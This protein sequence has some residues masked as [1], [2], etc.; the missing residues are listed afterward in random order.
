MNDDGFAESEALDLVGVLSTVDECAYVWDL[1]TD[2][3]K[4]ESN[5]ASV[6]GLEDIDNIVS[7]SDFEQR[8]VCEHRARRT[9]AIAASKACPYD[10]GVP[11]RVQYRFKPGAL[12]GTASIWIED[13]GRWWPGDDGK[14]ALARGTIRVVNESFVAEQA[15]LHGPERDEL[16]NHLNRTRLPHAVAAAIGRAE[17]RRA[18]SAFLMIAVNNL[19]V[20]NETFGFEIGDEVLS[21]T[22]ATIKRKLRS[23]DVMG[24]YS[25]NKFGVILSNCGTGAMRIAAERFMKAVRQTPIQTSA[26][27]MTATVSIGG[28]TIPEQAS[29]VREVFSRSLHAL[30]VAKSRRFDS[31]ASFEVDTGHQLTRQR[32]IE[33]ADDIMAALDDHRMRLVLQPIISSKTR[34]A[35]FYE[36]LLR[37]EK[38]DGTIVSAGEFIPF[39]EQFGLLRLIDKRTM[40]LTV[41]M[42]K[43]HPQLSLSVNVSSTT[44]TDR[45]WLATLQDLTDEDRSLTKRLVVEITETTVIDD[46]D[47]AVAFVDTLREMGCRVAI[48]DFGAGYTSFKNLKHLPVDVVK[49]DGAFVKNLAVD[50]S[51]KIF[52]KTMVELADTFGMET[53]AEWVADAECAD[54]LTQAGITYLQGFHFGFPLTADELAVELE[55]AE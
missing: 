25:S 47:Q 44:T 53:V 37:M 35:S 11:Y 38:P 46:I 24:R 9:A 5:A 28:V 23:G 43:K 19:A 34:K 41:A 55:A 2:T 30:E 21:A 42:L 45:D 50:S 27:Q 29:S 1:G 49:I 15:A 18:P 22:A 32:R 3:L 8:V 6:L 4:W 20:V 13:H 39:A 12:R 17:R 16:S 48:D 33:I 10:R 51:D 36:C 7:G 40:E 31:F 26:C 54:I 14:P 52:I